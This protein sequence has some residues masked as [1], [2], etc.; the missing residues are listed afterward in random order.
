MRQLRAFF[1][2]LS[3]LFR[4]R[5]RERELATEL[6][7]HLQLHIADNLRF[8]MTPAEARRQALLKLGGLEQTKE[9]C[10]ERKSLPALETLLRDFRHG[11]RMLRKNPGFTFVVVFTLALGIGA[12]TAIFS[13]L[14]S[15]LWRPLPF[16]DSERLV[17]A[18]VVLRANAHQWD[19]LPSSVYRAWREQ[20]HS[21]TN[22]GAYDYPTARNLT[23]AGTSERVAVMPVTAGLFDTLEVPLEHGRIFLPEEETT[24]RDHVAI[25]SHALWQ[26]RF[27]SD[28]AVIGKPITID[29]QP[30]TIVGIAPPHLRFE[31][32]REPGIYIPLATDPAGKVVR[33]TYVIARL[34]P[35]TTA[36][37]ARVELDGIL[38]RQLQADGAKQEDA[39][40]VTNLRETWTDFAARPLYFFAGAV[41]L[42]LLIACVNNAGLL[43]ARG[44]ARRREFA[45]RAA[46]GAGRAALIRQSLAESLLLSLAGGATGTLIG[47]WVSNVFAL[48]W[49]EEALPRTTATYLDTRVLF[50]VVGVSIASAL[51]M[52]IMPALFSSRV[53]IND[54]LR[55]GTSGLSASRSQHKTRNILVALEVSLALVL[56]FGAGLFLSS[57][58]RLRHAPRG[59][60]APGALTFRISLRGENYA[61]PEQQ[62]RYFRTLTDQLRSLPGMASLTFGSGIPLDGSQL[63]SSVHVAGRPPRG[64][65][66]IGVIVYAVEPNFFELLHMHLLEGRTLDPHDAE[67]SARVAIVNRNA[68]H[69]LLG[70]EDPLGKI[71][72]YVPDERRGV[73]PEAPVQIVGVTENAQEFG[74]NEI[75]FDVIYVPFSQHP[76]PS[77]AVVV[78]SALPRGALLGAIRDAAYSLDKDQPIFDVKT[79]DDRI[80][81]SL[82]GARFDLILVACLA[83]VALALVSVGIFGTVAYFVQ[84]RTQEFGVRLAL[85]ATASHILRHAISRALIM[86]VTGLLFGVAASLVLGRILRSALYLVPHEHTGML[87][88]VK[89]FDPLSMSFACVLLLAIL[90][91]ASF[92]PARRAMRVD[93]VVALRY[94]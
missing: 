65:H 18:H 52:G 85:G 78:S 59:F 25:L 67:S 12:N 30:Y 38:R 58:V 76:S 21:F 13:V 75:P 61:R 36:E 68:A 42:V 33:N 14:E 69:T 93:P 2:R 66:G 73:P 11:L 47:I 55:K 64:E 54:A 91:F 89:F 24:G 32:M 94:E 57:F 49:S 74:A 29:G 16:P 31:Y 9:A 43:L 39:A 48:F 4:K 62:Q 71:L 53:D 83:A 7:S 60:D 40:S 41:F 46:L 35:G 81:D 79:M 22:L 3:E 87:Y 90:F 77:A 44:L 56:L 15:Q 19:L 82:R 10:R 37:G 27:S 45:L 34:A 92:V 5:R 23:A 26:T 70:S 17:D 84:Q 88:G 50:F 28:A 20:S 86:G 80:A 6:E 8:G 51:L 63:Y 1:V 72:E